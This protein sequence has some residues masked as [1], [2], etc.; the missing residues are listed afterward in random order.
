MYLDL[1]YDVN[2]HCHFSPPVHQRRNYRIKYY[3]LEKG[4]KETRE[5]KKTRK[6]AIRKVKIN[7]L[8]IR[9]IGFRI[10]KNAISIARLSISWIDQVSNDEKLYRHTPIEFERVSQ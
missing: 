8:K 1:V 3:N 2:L 5:T 10:K 9:L 6:R 7:L 4:M